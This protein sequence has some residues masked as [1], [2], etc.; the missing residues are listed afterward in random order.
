MDLSR[1]KVLP[2][3]EKTQ[4]LGFREAGHPIYETY[5]PEGLDRESDSQQKGDLVPDP[6]W[7]R[8]RRP[9]RVK[10]VTGFYSNRWKRLCEMWGRD[11]EER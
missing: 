2:R 1:A 4:N 7:P 3:T 8:G 6:N 5:L 10:R 11:E 9:K